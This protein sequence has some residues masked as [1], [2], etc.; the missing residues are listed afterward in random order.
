MMVLMRKQVAY[1]G[2]CGRKIVKRH[3]REILDPLIL[4]PATLP[5]KP[6]SNVGGHQ[7]SSDRMTLSGTVNSFLPAVN[8]I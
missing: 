1:F 5:Y 2:G 7:S 6:G 4:Q 3:A 8:Y